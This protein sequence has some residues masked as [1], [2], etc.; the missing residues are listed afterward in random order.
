MK[1][2]RISTKQ[3]EGQSKCKICGIVN[4]SC[5]MIEFKEMKGHY[6]YQCAKKLEYENILS[7]I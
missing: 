7:N 5:M 4:W 3:Y 2:T 1:L 6:C